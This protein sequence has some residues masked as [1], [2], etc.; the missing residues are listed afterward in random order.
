M[1]LGRVFFTWPRLTNVLHCPLPKAGSI[2][3]QSKSEYS[4]T[5]AEF[6]VPD[7]EFAFQILLK[8]KGYYL[9]ANPT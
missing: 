4:V 7:S 8:V 1:H 3:E 2:S 5:D 9:D 6:D